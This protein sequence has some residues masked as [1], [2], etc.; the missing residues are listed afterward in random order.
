[1]FTIRPDDLSGTQT[2]QLL[3]LH[4][5]AMRDGSPPGTSF[6]LDLSGL[7]SPDVAVWSAW[8]GDAIVGIGALKRHPDGTAELKSMRTH[9]DHLRR[10]VAARLLEHI[11]QAARASGARRLSLETGDGP[12][13]AAA[14]SLYTRRGFVEG[15]T[16]GDYV[17]GAFNRFFHLDLRPLN[18]KATRDPTMGM[19]E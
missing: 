4:V 14:L 10:G 8:D 17:P 16:F 5:A 2:R 19:P 12:G 7:A 6:A 15:E 11:I 1:M 9:P 18:P 3:A 13:F